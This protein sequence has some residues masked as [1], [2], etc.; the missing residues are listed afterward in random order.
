MLDVR[1]T[2][3]FSNTSRQAVQ[4]LRAALMRHGFHLEF[5]QEPPEGHPAA[6]YIAFPGSDPRAVD[7]MVFQLGRGRVTAEPCVVRGDTVVATSMD[8]LLKAMRRDYRLDLVSRIRRAQRANQ[9]H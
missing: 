9:A 6:L 4:R 8:T 1:D 7:W 5:A 2:Q 3:P